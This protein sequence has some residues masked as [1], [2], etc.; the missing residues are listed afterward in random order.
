MHGSSKPRL[1]HIS[2]FRTIEIRR[3]KDRLSIIS[4]Y[5][6]QCLMVNILKHIDIHEN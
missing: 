6:V 2:G 4:H 5:N 1:F 3:R